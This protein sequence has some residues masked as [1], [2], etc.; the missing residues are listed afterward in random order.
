MVNGSFLENL[1]IWSMEISCH[2]F[3]LQCEFYCYDMLNV[4]RV[5]GEQS[6]VQGSGK[7]WTNVNQLIYIRIVYHY[8]FLCFS[9]TFFTKHDVIYLL[10]SVP[11]FS[12]KLYSFFYSVRTIGSVNHIYS[13]ELV[14][15]KYANLVSLINSKRV[16][17]FISF[18]LW[19]SL[20]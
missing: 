2:Y 7:K 8:F 6:F 16:I 3:K 10:S 19:S 15:L 4:L 1:L 5:H 9:W 20:Q 12:F 14:M 13:M 18:L 17:Y 11:S